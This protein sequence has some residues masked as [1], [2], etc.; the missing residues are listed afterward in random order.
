MSD[1]PMLISNKLHS[2]RNFYLQIYKKVT[3]ILVFVA[4]FR[5][6]RYDIKKH[7]RN[8]QRIRPCFKQNVTT[9]LFVEQRTDFRLTDLYQVGRSQFHL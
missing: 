8:S 9:F 6:S 7:G 4:I 3:K 1:Y 5:S 2:F